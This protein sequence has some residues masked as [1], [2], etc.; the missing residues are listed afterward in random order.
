MWSELV[1]GLSRGKLLRKKIFYLF[2]HDLR[3]GDRLRLEKWEAPL[4]ILKS[5]GGH[6]GQVFYI[7]VSGGEELKKAIQLST[8]DWGS[9]R[10]NPD[11]KLEVIRYNW[12]TVEKRL[13]RDPDLH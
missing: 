13:G 5:F 4:E 9:R 12:S 10:K 6:A 2:C 3:R 8:T 11:K 7:E 1:N